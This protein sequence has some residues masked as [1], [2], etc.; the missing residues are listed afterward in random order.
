MKGEKYFMINNELKISGGGKT[1][2][3]KYYPLSG[4]FRFLQLY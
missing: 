1:N 2:I 3:M 4:D